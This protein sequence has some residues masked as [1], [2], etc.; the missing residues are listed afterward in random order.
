M[1]LTP[2]QSAFM[3]EMTLNELVGLNIRRL[4]QQ[5]GIT[6][7]DLAIRL[8]LFGLD[9]T[10]STIT[11]LENGKKVLDLDEFAA[12]LQGFGGTAHELF[13]A[14]KGQEIVLPDGDVIGIEAITEGF[15]QSKEGHPLTVWTQGLAEASLDYF[16]SRDDREHLILLGAKNEAE[17][18]VARSLGIP[19]EEVVGAALDTWG[20]TLT[21][22]REYRLADWLE[23]GE[24]GPSLRTKRGQITRELVTE[25]RPN[26]ISED[27]A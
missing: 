22:E 7:Q 5:H 3:E 2:I 1:T 8:R 11:N 9:W 23:T 16:S 13:T 6:A 25:I 12:L 27:G 18:K 17:Q 19:V 4:R 14:P 20:R 24:T 10:R 15:I 21:D 26:L